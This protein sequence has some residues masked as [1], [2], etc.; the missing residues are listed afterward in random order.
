VV[1]AR[2]REGRK[3]D[4]V[5]TWW[6]VSVGAVFAVSRQERDGCLIRA[7]KQETHMLIKGTVR[8]S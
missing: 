5:L 7:A 1:G 2:R 4:D 6:M 8:C 3:D